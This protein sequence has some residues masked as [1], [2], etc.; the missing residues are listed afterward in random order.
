MDERI[1]HKNDVSASRNRQDRNVTEDR[2][3]GRE[4]TTLSF[5]DAFSFNALPDLPHIP[6]F[7]TIWLTTNNPRDTI[8]AR[9]RLGYVSVSPTE[10]PGWENLRVKSGEYEGMVGVNEMLAFKLPVELYQRYMTQMHYDAPL[11][12]EGKIKAQLELMRDSR[13]RALARDVGDGM[14]ELDNAPPPPPIFD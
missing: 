5:K 12:E 13:G 9:M 2:N 10:I 3:L 11:Q 14:A 1:V 6:G 8:A 7:K 4:E